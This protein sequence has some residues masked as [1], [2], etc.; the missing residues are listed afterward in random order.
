M[1][2]TIE[3]N[4]SDRNHRGIHP[5]IEGTV[6][7]ETAAHTPIAENYTLKII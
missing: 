4:T 7:C 3:V 1:T 5:V 6:K 2:A